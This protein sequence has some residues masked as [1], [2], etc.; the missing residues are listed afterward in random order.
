MDLEMIILSEVSQRKMNT[1]WNHLYMESKKNEKDTNEFIYRMEVDSDI[2]NK[3][4]VTK[5]DR[6]GCGIN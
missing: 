5:G 6:W 3:F 4:V 2:K 1:T